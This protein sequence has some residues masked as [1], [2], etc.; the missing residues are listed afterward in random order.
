MAKSVPIRPSR[1][2]ARLFLT[3][4]ETLS[5]P[6]DVRKK[7]TLSLSQTPKILYTA[8]SKHLSKERAFAS[9]M[10]TASKPYSKKVDSMTS[11]IMGWGIATWIVALTPSMK[12]YCGYKFGERRSRDVATTTTVV[13]RDG[14]K[15][16]YA[17]FIV[18]AGIL[19]RMGIS[20]RRSLR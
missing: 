4:L 6:S 18:C 7:A 3:S 9:D 8:L 11:I 13:A 5:K 19:Q 2:L 17:V 12:K 14:D 20:Q 15:L 16:A 1:N 10:F